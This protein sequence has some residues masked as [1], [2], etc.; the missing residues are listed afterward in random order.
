VITAEQN[1]LETD[2]QVSPDGC[3]RV[4]LRGIRLWLK[5][6][7]RFLRTF[8]VQKSEDGFGKFII[9]VQQRLNHENR[10]WKFGFIEPAVPSRPSRK[11]TRRCLPKEVFENQLHG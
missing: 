9:S 7:L 5:F 8:A 10:F 3:G 6:W 4:V 11:T 2:V 1:E